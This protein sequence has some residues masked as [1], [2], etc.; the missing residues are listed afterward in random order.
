MLK[1]NSTIKF[2]IQSICPNLII[3]LIGTETKSHLPRNK[4]IEMQTEIYYTFAEEAASGVGKP[5]P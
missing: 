5:D 1:I 2:K 4:I 3:L